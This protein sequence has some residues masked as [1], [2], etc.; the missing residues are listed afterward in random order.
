MRPISYKW[1]K[2]DVKEVFEETTEV[3][4]KR[5]DNKIEIPVSVPKVIGIDE[6]GKSIIE[7]TSREGARDHYGFVAQEVKQALDEIGTGDL[8]AGWVLDDHTDPESRQNLRYTEF[9]SPMVKAI[10]ELSDMVESLQQEV[11][12]LK[13]I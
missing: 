5:G 9:I 10:Q 6:N 1:K 2:T 8:F 3:V 7:T 11:N 12:T 4:E 13:G